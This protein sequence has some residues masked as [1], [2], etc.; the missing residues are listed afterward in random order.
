MRKHSSVA[1]RH[2]RVTIVSLDGHLAGAAER[3]FAG[4]RKD[5]PNLTATLHCAGEWKSDPQRLEDCR[6]DIAQADIVIACMLF[7]DEHIQQIAP[8]LKARR[9]QCDAMVCFM[10]DG[11]IMK[12]TR[13]GQFKMD[14]ST[15]GPM[16]LL[17]RLRGSKKAQKS[18][19]AKQVAMLQRLP[20]IL[21]F[22]PG[23]AQ[24]VR[25]YFLTMQYWLAGSEQNIANMVRYLTLRYADVAGKPAR[26]E[27]G[28]PL[29]VDYPQV[30]IY[31]PCI[32]Q[33]VSE[34]L[35]DLPAEKGVRGTVGLLVM[36]AYVL[37]GNCRHYD[38]VIRAMEAQGLRVIPVFA[39]GLDA[40][41]AIEQYFV[42][43]NEAVVDAVVSLTGFSLVGGPAY[44]DSAA[45]EDMLARLDVPYLAA[46]CSEFQSLEEWEDSSRGLLPVETTLMVAIPELDGAIAPTLFAGRSNTNDDAG[47]DMLPHTERIDTLVARTC[48]LIDLRRTSRADRTLGVLLFNFPPNAGA[49]GSAA[50]L[51]VFESLYN[52]LHTLAD[53]GYTVELPESVDAL[54]EAILTGNAADYGTDANVLAH[55]PVDDYVRRERWLADIEACW[56]PAPGKHLSNGD[57]LFVLGKQ[58]GNVHVVVQPSFGY[59]GDPMRLLFEQG[60]APTHAFSAFYRY[61]R[62]DLAVDAMLNFGTHGALEFM[63]GKQVGMSDA[64]WPERLL[65]DVPNF[66]LYAANNPSEGVLAKR[67]SAAT[68]ISYLTPAI[69]EAGLHRELSDLQEAIDRWREQPPEAQSER[70]A[71]A[72]TI[73]AQAI[74]LELTAPEPVWDGDADLHI[75]TLMARLNEF[76]ETLIP[77]GM[78]VVGEPLTRDVRRDLLKAMEGGDTLPAKALDALVD[79]GAVEEVC[80]D[81][82][83]NQDAVTRLGQAATLLS[84][85]HR[86]ETDAIVQALDGRYIRPVVGGDLIKSPDILPT[87]RNIHGFDP[88][89]IPSSFAVSDGARQ[90]QLLLDKHLETSGTLPESVAFVLWGTDNLK[91]QGG[92]IGQVLALLGA[93]PR[94]DSYG[95]LCGAE[96]IPLETL[97]RPRIDVVMT[98]SGIFR[99]LL[100]HQIAMLAE[101]AFL[102]A[103]VDEP[104]EQNFVRKHALAYMQSCDCDLETA[105]MRVFSNAEGAYG[106]NVNH[107]VEN[108]HWQDEDELANTYMRRKCFGYTRDGLPQRQ[109]E[110]LSRSLQDV[111]LAYQNIESVELG[112]TS[113]DNYFDTLGGITKA[114]QQVS[115]KQIEVYIG[116]QTDGREQVRTLAD[117]VALEAHSR[118]L[119]PT[120]Y[121][122]MLRHGFE[123]VRQI[124]NHVTNTMGLSATT[125]KVAPWVYEKLTQLYILDPEMRDRM[126]ELNPTASARVVGRLLE[127]QER[128]YWSPDEETLEQIR[129]VGDELDDRLEG[130]KE[131]VA[132]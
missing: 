73:Q 119:N 54:R 20:R 118:M 43:E 68:L 45:A 81:S 94:Y 15:S 30:G 25:A 18:N 38:Q 84:E 109:P 56:G 80:R 96:L 117:Q 3:A 21:R 35:D 66:Y 82:Q 14:G 2:Y 74:D 88:F 9:D 79:G 50:F 110:L 12:L 116:D 6:A 60:H 113:I 34:S 67:R 105:A 32:K 104:A 132:A 58:F 51:A 122:G 1:E 98:L 42:H 59:E 124:E 107:L 103:S 76:R 123:G 33:G 89:R 17:K 65:G 49:T 92:P 48:K 100:P 44:N 4:L 61:L 39:S 16:A 130:I 121:E 52:T 97:G 26:C 125:G 24:D 120:W 111:D 7:L 91:S 86:Y 101:A 95:R 75:M 5:L 28:V 41:P 40:R 99:D 57:G 63:P 129:D 83:L 71:L 131:V 19:G 72:S 70:D 37:A 115:G 112:V 47:R 102:A 126:A 55:I 64:C 22:I 87:G 46:H 77:H 31:H 93:Q 114:A 8:A 62:E 10:S 127:A 106:G 85:E 108:S 69:T 23:T 27:S 53:A 13:I 36:R 29:P 90:A 128:N 78:H 11:E